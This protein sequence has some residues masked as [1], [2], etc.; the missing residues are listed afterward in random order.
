MHPINPW[1][2]LAIASALAAALPW[3]WAQAPGGETKGSALVHTPES[4]R[5]VVEQA[6]VALPPQTTGGEIF[7]GRWKDAP[8]TPGRPPVP[9]VVF[10]H[11]SSGLGL[12]AIGEW[13]R[14]LAGMGIASVAP[15]SFALPDRL[16]YKSPVSADIYERVHA[17]R[18]SEVSLAVQALAG[19]PWADPARW[20]LAGTSEGATA[21]ARYPGNEFAGRI[22]FSWSC[23]NNY[24]VRE[25]G[26]ALPSDRPVLNIISSTD[27]YFSPA[28]PW[29]GNGTAQ[30]HCASAL[31]HHKQASVVLIPGA[32]HT[33]LGL[34]AA[35]HPVAGFLQ[36]LFKLH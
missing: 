7:V 28:N 5:A 6:Q 27:P 15:D 21:V 18:L 26:T 3:A 20:V 36:D 1:K 16:T 13:Q 30:G 25:H 9:V 35:R 29:L 31:R 24:F 2:R 19:A 17:L 34:P 32:P 12:K 10:M 23:E 11:G 22:V 4:A 14:W 33:V 8:A